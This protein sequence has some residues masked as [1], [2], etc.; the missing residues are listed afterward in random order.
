[1]VGAQLEGARFYR[2]MKNSRSGVT[3]V[4]PVLLLA[5]TE[6]R[7]T[8]DLYKTEQSIL[9]TE[10]YKKKSEGMSSPSK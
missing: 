2:R 5:D 3:V 1:M 7:I 4:K 8:S 9:N 6:K 10:L